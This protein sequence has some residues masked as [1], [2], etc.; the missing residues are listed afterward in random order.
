MHTSQQKS[1]RLFHRAKILALI[2]IGYNIVEGLISVWLGLADE[3]VAL[4]GFG[5]DSFVEVIS[6]IGIYHM[7]VRTEG[8]GAG[9]R[10]AF[11]QRALRI[12]GFAFYLLA[13]G[14][15]VTAGISAVEGHRPITALW[16][17]VI[18]LLSILTMGVLIHMKLK[19]GRALQSDAIIADAHCT[20]AC[21]LLS[22]ALLISGLGYELTGIA[23]FDSAGSVAI[24]FLSLR[25]GREAFAKARNLGCGCSP[26]QN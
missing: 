20:R 22:F 2:T 16:G 17:V 18:A 9:Q 8:N 15:V 26:G 13:A 3:T 25:E 11:E 5:L 1:V 10:D 12:T 4:F 19:V 7:I 14:L 21:L 6:G 24:A 23:G